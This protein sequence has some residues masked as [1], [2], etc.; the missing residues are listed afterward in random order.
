MELALSSRTPPPLKWLSEKRARVHS[1][2]NNAERLHSQLAV[3]AAKWAR[4]AELVGSKAEAV[5]ARR[6]ALREDLASLDHTLALYDPGIDAEDIAPIN[7]TKDR[8]GKRGTLR[9]SVVEAVRA[10]PAG[11]LTTDE[12]SCAVQLAC[13]LVFETMEARARWMRNSFKRE[14]KRLANEGLAVRL[15]SADKSH[16]GRWAWKQPTRVTLADLRSAA[17]SSALDEVEA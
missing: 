14:L 9:R 17:P 13:G 15:H 6:E 10:A 5:A 8:Y 16:L 7:A 12:V 3:R 2:L 4:R 1:A 11:G